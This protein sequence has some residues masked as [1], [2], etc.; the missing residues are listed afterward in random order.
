MEAVALLLCLGAAGA[1]H[2]ADAGVLPH[3]ATSPTI[4]V[5][6]LVGSA[7]LASPVYGIPTL[8]SANGNMALTEGTNAAGEPAIF[9]YD[10]TGGHWDATPA[11]VLSSPDTGHTSAFFP[12]ALSADASTLVVGAPARGQGDWSRVYIYS[13]SN[14]SW[15]PTP[16]AELGNPRTGGDDTDGFGDR[17]SLSGD[18]STLL[19][20]DSATIDGVPYE[21]A[22]YLYRKVAGAWE[23][24]PDATFL[25]PDPIVVSGYGVTVSLTHFGYESTSVSPDGDSVLVGDP[26]N[27][28]PGK[29]YLYESN[30]DGTWPT[31]PQPVAV[32]QR[33][34]PSGTVDDGFG[35]HTALS[36]NGTEAYV[37][38]SNFNVTPALYL[39]DKNNG[40]WSTDM[41][42][43]FVVPDA[44]TSAFADTHFTLSGDGDTLFLATY[45]SQE[46][47]P[48]CCGFVYIYRRESGTWSQSPV[49]ELAEPDQYL[50]PY[51]N[52]FGLTSLVATTD[53]STVM[54][55]DTQPPNATPAWG[56]PT[57]QGPGAAFVFHTTDDWAQPYTGGGTP[58]PSGSPGGG[59]SQSGGG[60]ALGGLVLA[61]LLLL[62]AGRGYAEQDRPA[63]S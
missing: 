42:R 1:F 49:N 53:G 15:S 55:G 10:Q 58:P 4:T 36:R 31:D 41:T 22:V 46:S 17:A 61:A 28:H 30:P 11:A 23:T 48:D 5:A 62:L 24:S 12:L 2:R 47:D 25:D 32:L 21:G 52:A 19:L 3:T 18:G 16:V 37:G 63:R 38:T 60:G 54:I 59:G 6:R 34:A 27:G 43:K 9:E 7:R 50:S 35:S 44:D 14:G 29:A 39:F 40:T 13:R 56:G 51:N 20:A 57:Y 26:A 33:P 45:Q 8:L